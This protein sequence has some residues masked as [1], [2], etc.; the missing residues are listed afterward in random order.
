MVL[1]SLCEPHQLRPAAQDIV[2]RICISALHAVWCRRICISVAVPAAAA[3]AAAVVPVTVVT[4]T[5]VP[6]TVV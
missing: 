5:V 2:R 4:V 1:L 6:V 3:A